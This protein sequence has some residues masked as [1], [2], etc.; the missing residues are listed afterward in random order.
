MKL[1]YIV[2]VLLPVLAIVVYTVVLKVNVLEIARTMSPQ[3]ILAFLLSYL[4]QVAVIA[5]RDRKLVGVSFFNAF[6]ARLLGNAVSLLV[7]GWVGQELTRA[8][9]YNKQGVDLVRAFSLSILEGYFDVTTGTAMFLA[10]LYFI[11]VKYIYIEIIYV[12]YAVGNLI[13][14]LSGITYVFFTA[15]KAVKIEQAI[16]KLAGFEKYHFILEIGKKAMKDRMNFTNSIY[17]YFLTALGYL[18]QSSPFYLIRPNVLEDLIVNMTLFIAFLFPIPGAAGVSEIA[19]SFY[20]PSH[21][22]I[23]VAILGFVEFL[24]GFVFIGE[25]NLD[26]LKN[27]LDKI[28]KYGELYKGP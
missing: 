22:V 7:P 16:I 15:N 14:W 18:V 1:K 10:L 6:K 20:L 11:P 13:G 21:Y 23:D 28:K 19:L 5:L 24:M 4:G 27:E 8:L 17:F 9:I 3:L 2:A 25:V 12:L 26:E